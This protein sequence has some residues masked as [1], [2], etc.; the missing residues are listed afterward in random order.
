MLLFWKKCFRS[1]EKM[2]QNKNILEQENI[3]NQDNYSKQENVPFIMKIYS[4]VDKGQ[5]HKYSTSVL[6][7]MN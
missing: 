1:R 4:G 3:L 6:H 7:N 2:A 5:G